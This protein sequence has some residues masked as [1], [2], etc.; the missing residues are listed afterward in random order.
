LAQ[1]GM[2]RCQFEVQFEN[3][4]E[5]G[6]SG[7]DSIEFIISPNPGQPL[8]P[9]AK[10]ASG[11]ELSRIMLAIKSIVVGVNDA[12]TIIFDEIDT[13]LDGRILQTVRDKL[14]RLAKSRQVLC[15]THQ[16]LIAAAADNH[17]L[18]EKTH[19]EESTVVT[20]KSLQ[21]QERIK[22][23][24]TMTSGHANE[25]LALSFAQSLMTTSNNGKSC[26]S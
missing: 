19:G 9:L 1:L 25:G 6:S 20:L 5:L 24:A 8:L 18:V 23:L 4:A 14:S 21:G 22:V 2:E 12:P 13:G 10:I 17:L 26:A 11:G 15:I 16:A 3:K 7:L